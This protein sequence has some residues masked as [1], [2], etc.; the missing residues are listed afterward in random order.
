MKKFA[1]ILMVLALT[2]NLPGQTARAQ[3]YRDNTKYDNLSHLCVRA[4]AQDSLGNMWI[5]TLA[6]LDKYNGYE[7]EYFQHNPADTCSIRS[8]FV[9]SLL[10]DGDN[11]LIGTA[12]GV[13]C[14]NVRTG[15][16]SRIP[17][18]TCP[19]Y[20]LFKD[21]TGNI[22]IASVEGLGLLDKASGEISYRKDWGE[23]NNM[24]EDSYGRLWLG[25][26][27]GLAL[28][29]GSARYFLPGER[30][31]LCCYAI[32]ESIWW[33]G[34]DKGI[35]LF[36]PVTGRSSMPD[37]LIPASSP[38]Q[39]GRIN[40]ITELSPS[41]LLIGT[42][43][44]GVWQ[45]DLVTHSLDNSRSDRFN[46]NNAAEI[47][48]CYKDSQGNTWI[49]SYEK[50]FVIAGK[51]SD[52]FNENTALTTPL[53]DKFVT[54]V[55]ED[56]QGTLWIS[57]RYGYLY[58]Y[59]SSEGF[60]NIDLG[61]VKP[62]GG[63][64][65]ECIFIDSR[66]RFWL[67][68]E[69]SLCLANVHSGKA[70]KI[71]SFPLDHVR[72]IR[73]DALGNI[74]MGA[75]SGLYNYRPQNREPEKVNINPALNITDILPM[76]NGEI[77]YSAHGWTVFKMKDGLVSGLD[78]PEKDRDVGRYCITMK[79]DSKNRIWL[80]SYG[81]GMLCL[82]GDNVV[83]ISAENGLPDSNI[84][85]FQEDL[86]GNIWVSTFHGIAR[87]D[88][89]KG[90]TTAT[91]LSFPGRQYH[92]KSGCRT[93]S[94]QI[95]FGGNHGLTF[96][97]PKSFAT[98]HPVPTIHLEDLKI[99]GQSVNPGDEGSVLKQNIAYTDRISLN[100][101][102]RSFSLDFAGNDFFSSN[103]LTYKYRLVGFDKDW[104]DAG[105][106]RRAS[107][108]NLRPGD[109]IFEAVAIGE[110]GVESTDP[111]RLQIHIK[112]VP[113]LSWWAL[114]AYL[115]LVL[116]IAW[117]LI[118]SAMHARLARERAEMERKE[119][120]RE[121]EMSQM[122]TIFF[123]NISHELRTPLTLISAPLERILAK[124]GQD[125]ETT[126]L[127]EGIH[128]NS[129]RMLMLIN[130]LMDITKIENGVYFLGVRYTDI[131]GILK[132]TVTSFLFLAEKQGINLLF[133][134][135]CASHMIWADEDKIVKIMDN[136]LSNAIKHTP[137]GGTIE[138]KTA[139]LKEAPQYDLPM[140][141][142]YFEVSVLDTGCGVPADQLD[143][144]FVRYRQIEGRRPDYSGNGIGLH[145]TRNMVEKHHG[146]IV[147]NLRPTGGMAFSFVLPQ[148]DVYSDSEKVIGNLLA[149][150]AESAAIVL[151]KDMPEHHT[152][153]VVEDNAELREFLTGLL[154]GDYSVLQAPD[155]DKAWDMLQNNHA[156]LVIS[157]VIMPGISGYELCS[158][159]KES[160]SLCHLPVILLTAKTSHQ[161][162]M[163]GLESGA[164]AY[165]CKPFHADLLQMTVRNLLKAKEVM[166]QYFSQPGI[167]G[168][169]FV[170]VD[171][172]EGDKPFLDKLTAI[173]AANISNPDLNID[174]MA[175]EMGYSRTAFYLKVKRLTSTAP[176][177][178]VRNYR[179]KAAAE[180]I[181]NS[182]APL[183]EISELCGF[184]SY[185]YFSKA[186]KQHF[187]VSP[188]S[189]RHRD[190]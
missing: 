48:C 10:M 98:G 72:S 153:M 7:F 186:F 44:A 165:I 52:F 69:K 177:D 26:L 162:Q 123:T 67:A 116:A 1:A 172:P 6:G 61:G 173:M 45:Y 90:D 118:R 24:W 184:G 9:F 163:E 60:K 130:Q 25:T 168:D 155:G 120:E 115:L 156:D 117:M 160:P 164:D 73:E 176:N 54:R 39:K 102:Q 170:E 119:K 104:V 5:G 93:A 71:S 180:M 51:Q 19:V 149:E 94:G 140:D 148:R 178:L 3:G 147:A 188:N 159:I 111:A 129:S 38:L 81:Y 27:T 139:F 16:I 113:W 28:E 169:S 12:M 2:A 79:R 43:I 64:Y 179:F 137:E 56:A 70:Y 21:H 127:L 78:L 58:S 36:N 154:G 83:R 95:Y 87:V 80:G 50:G 167:S 97:D 35:V 92:E 112:Q 151:Q 34:T 88:L 86:S 190:V 66:G 18:P 14:R 145:Y 128:R 62:L 20:R 182:M 103:N 185:S 121:K 23:I 42:A 77:W 31:V 183:T 76:D 131:I 141:D 152:L 189:W 89:P 96:F 22:R 107:Y 32:S 122:K 11:L 40:F 150:K 15:R 8:D 100:H 181:R 125:S 161:E 59:S 105:T 17:G 166:R 142:G 68:F 53:E 30:Q 13:D 132:D 37:N 41:K 138:V 47:T 144:L 114:L 187:G 55:V 4:F 174:M 126:S 135:H 136:L 101:M 65:L 108:S 57:D 175:R 75:W 143:Q 157:D 171:L 46:P 91:I 29:D 84:L 110:G 63:D 82:D 106:Y 124:P 134:P 133:S 49:G 74:W 109:Y 33:L 146:K 99:W 158:R 85:S